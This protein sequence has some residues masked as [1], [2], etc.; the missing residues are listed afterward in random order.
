M[1]KLRPA[2]LPFDFAAAPQ[3]YQLL[4]DNQTFPTLGISTV[5][6]STKNL[7]PPPPPPND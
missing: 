6:S 2:F 4:E 3:A 7:F 5:I 1:A